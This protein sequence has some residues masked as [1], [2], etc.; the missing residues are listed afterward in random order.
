[1]ERLRKYEHPFIIRAT[2]W[3]NFI[4]LGMMVASGL[5]IYDASPVFSFRIPV[6][7]T[8]GGWL[9]GARQWHFF[10]M[11][12]FLLN[13]VVW[14]AYNIVSRHG[15]QTTIFSGKDAGGILPT[16]GYYLRIRKEHPPAGKYNALQ[17]LAY[18]LVAFVAIGALVTGVGIYWPVQ[19][20][21]VTSLFGGY[22]ICR[23]WHFLFM[24]ALVAFFAG[25]LF[26]VCVSG[27][28]NFVSI[29]TGWKKGPAGPSK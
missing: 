16:I 9:G 11:W 24:A 23:V 6:I 21:P 13:G 18:T 17:K 2:H 10:A 7:L 4:A 22:D 20:S 5:R 28:S 19:F 8:L 27:W 25:H 12:I 26:M 15:R 1:M 3:I 29:L 14:F